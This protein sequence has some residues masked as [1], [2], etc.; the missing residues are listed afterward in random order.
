[1]GYVLALDHVPFI[2]AVRYI[3]GFY[4]TCTSS[5]NESTAEARGSNV[6]HSCRLSVYYNGFTCF[7]NIFKATDCNTRN[8]I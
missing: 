2:N 1:M 8:V 4:I 7:S 3:Y 5:L 6:V